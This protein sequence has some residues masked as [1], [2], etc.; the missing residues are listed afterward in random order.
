M[1]DIGEPVAVE[2]REGGVPCAFSD[3][4]QMKRA[5]EAAQVCA[6]GGRRSKNCAAGM[7]VVGRFALCLVC[8][9]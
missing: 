4:H 3:G 9:A 6:A 8:A 2:A 1:R 7:A 5:L